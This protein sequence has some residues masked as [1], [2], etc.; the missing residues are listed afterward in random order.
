MWRYCPHVAD[1]NHLRRAVS[2]IL[3]T[4]TGEPLDAFLRRLRAAGKS[5]EAIARE[6]SRTTDGL[7]DLSFR[8]MSRWLSDLDEEEVA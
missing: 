4:D 8:T 1:F 3:E 6:L 2:H 7:F 5:Y